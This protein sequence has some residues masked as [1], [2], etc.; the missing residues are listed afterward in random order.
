MKGNVGL[1]S[2]KLTLA[3]LYN[4]RSRGTIVFVSILP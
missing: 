2:L 3:K 1:C 4:H